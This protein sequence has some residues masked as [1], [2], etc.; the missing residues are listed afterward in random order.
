MLAELKLEFER[1]KFVKRITA[2]HICA[3][4]LTS[5]IDLTLVRLEES[6]SQVLGT[7]V[8]LSFFVR[9]LAHTDDPIVSAITS[10]GRKH[11]TTHL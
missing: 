11:E 4:S 5:A 10:L 8:H 7:F 6:L 9:E 1:I 3:E 2:F